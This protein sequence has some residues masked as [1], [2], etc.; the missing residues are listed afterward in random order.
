V[1]AP[2]RILIVHP[3][4]LRGENQG[5]Y[6]QHV[7]SLQWLL[8]GKTAE[9]GGPRSSIP[10]SGRSAA[11]DIV[12]VHMLPHRE[13][14]TS[15]SAASARC[16]PPE[17]SDTSAWRSPGSISTSPLVR[18]RLLYRHLCDAA[19]TPGLQLFARKPRVALFDPYVPIPAERRK[20]GRVCVRLGRNDDARGRSARLGDNRGLQRGMQMRSSRTWATAMFQRFPRN[21]SEQA[22]DAVRCVRLYIDSCA[23]R[24]PGAFEGP[25]F[26][27]GRSDMKLL[28]YAASFVAPVLEDVA[29]RRARRAR[30]ALP[31]RG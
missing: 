18:Q 29:P 20:T 21:P 22:R 24:R 4:T 12:V 16:R 14:E 28:T 15:A 19:G 9:R 27:A 2:R 1:T 25:A 11:G 10:R 17:L 5:V 7:S 31:R 30:A 13:I 8:D 3:S 6:V 26:T 23:C